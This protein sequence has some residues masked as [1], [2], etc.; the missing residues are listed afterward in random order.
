[1]TTLLAH[2]KIKPGREAQFEAIMKDMVAKTL[3][4]E[5]GVLRYEYYKA[6]A[7]N[8]YY[9]LLAFKD[10]WS[11]F[12]RVSYQQVRTIM[13]APYRRRHQRLH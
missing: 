11:R 10:K 12:R 6:Q 2:I 8:T 13:L 9:C 1:M 7:E 4:L 5:P 3:G